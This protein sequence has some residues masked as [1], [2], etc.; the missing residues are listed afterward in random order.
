[1]TDPTTQNT[2]MFVPIRGTDQGTW[3]IPVNTNFN[4]LDFMLGGVTTYTPT[5]T[6]I[7]MASTAAQAA[8]IRLTGTLTGNV[9]ITMAGINKLWT[10]ENLLT[11][12]PSSFCVSFAST[13][14]SV[15][16]GA[17]PGAQDIYYDGINVKYR[18]LDRIGN[19]SDYVGTAVPTWVSVCTVPPY[20]NCNGT[21][22][23]SG[24]YPILAN[25]L[26]TTTLPDARGKSRLT[27]DQSA[28]ILSSAVIGFSP[29]TVSAA[30]G[31]TT[32]TLSSLHLPKLVDVSHTHV[33]NAAING[34]GS[35]TPGPFTQPLNGEGA[36]TIQAAFT[37]LTYGSSAQIAVNTVQPSFMGGITMIRAA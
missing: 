34:G 19:Y 9:A 16:V 3:D 28:G 22:F 32:V 30:G 6:P 2:S 33:T 20:L 10:V 1:M 25:L 15:V 11:N 26:G 35:G 27:L 18:M 29:N 37:G 24:T 21:A 5:N 13:S 4:Y 7:T 17:P 14:G 8:I 12:S 31:Q 36:A 23:S